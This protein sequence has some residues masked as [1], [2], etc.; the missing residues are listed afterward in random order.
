MKQLGMN[1]TVNCQAIERIGVCFQ[2]GGQ[3]RGLI[4]SQL[5][6]EIAADQ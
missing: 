4:V 5:A 6:V 2:Q 3:A 1:Q